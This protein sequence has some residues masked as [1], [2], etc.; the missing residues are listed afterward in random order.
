MHGGDAQNKANGGGFYYGTE[1][2]TI[3]DAMLLCEAANN[4]S[5]FVP[6]ERAIGVEL[7]PEDPF[8]C[9]NIH[10]CRTSN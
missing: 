8:A 10:T 4:P 6:S 5:S 3:V 9:H 7:V 1:S 2:L